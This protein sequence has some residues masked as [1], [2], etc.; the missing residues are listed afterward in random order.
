MLDWG[1]RGPGH[2][3]VSDRDGEGGVCG[4]DRSVRHESRKY[5]KISLW[6]VM[7]CNLVGPR[8]L[9]GR[10]QYVCLSCLVE[11]NGGVLTSS[12]VSCVNSGKLL[13]S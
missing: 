7:G 1:H 5:L 3:L 10:Y 6:S 2:H 4:W 9:F 8:K 11:E 13:N 12:L